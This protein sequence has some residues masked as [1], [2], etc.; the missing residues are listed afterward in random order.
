MVAAV[1]YLEETNKNILNVE[2]IGGIWVA[3]DDSATVE[4]VK[5]I[6]PNYFPNVGNNTIYW[7]TGGVQGGPERQETATHTDKAV[8]RYII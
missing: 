2:D 3:S 5:E 6:A 4:K 8:S 1:K 7:I